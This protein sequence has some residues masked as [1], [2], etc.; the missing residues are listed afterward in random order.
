VEIEINGY[1]TYD[2][3]LEKMDMDTIRRAHADLLRSI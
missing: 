3:K 1:L 2:R